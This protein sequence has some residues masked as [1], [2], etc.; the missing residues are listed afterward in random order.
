MKTIVPNYYSRF[1]CIA[2]ACRHSCCIGWEIDIDAESFARYQTLPGKTGEKLRQNTEMKGGCAHFRMQGAQERCPMLN[3]EGLCELILTYGEDALCQIC[4]DHPR[5]RHFWTGRTEIGLG[6]CCE[7]A[8]RLI[9]SQEEIVQLTAIADDGREDAADEEETALLRVRSELFQL[10][11]DRSRPVEARVESL[12]ALVHAKPADFAWDEWIPILLDLERLDE[13]WAE[14]IAPLQDASSALSLPASLQIPMEQLMIYLLYRHLPE[15][16]A[17]GDARGHILLCCLLWLL[18]AQL[19]V[20]YAFT[21]SELTECCRM[22]S[23]EIEYSEDNIA[24]LLDEIAWAFA[25]QDFY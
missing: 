21:L 6:L 2:G 1:A 23:S 3:H 22:L 10:M 9:L 19:C 24:A 15:A 5:F 13:R 20:H 14:L 12:L 25:P 16:R 4:A 7:E 17:D 18:A 8:A 11:Q